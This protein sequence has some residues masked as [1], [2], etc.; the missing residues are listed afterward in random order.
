MKAILSRNVILFISIC[1]MLVLNKEGKAQYVIPNPSET[2]PTGNVTPVLPAN[3]TS[4]QIINYIRTITPTTPVTVES[5]IQTTDY[6]QT[7]VRTEYM[8]GLGRTIQTVDHFTSPATND[9]VS[10]VKYDN[11]G[12]SAWQF[13]PYT[14]TETT[15]SDNGKFKLNAYSEQKDFYKNTMGYTADNYFYTQINYEASPLNRPIYSMPQGSS[16]VGNTRGTSIIENSLPA[17]LNVRHFTIAYNP[18]SLPVTSAVYPT[19]DLM[20]KTTTDEDG[21][22]TE[23][24]RNKTDQVILKAT[25][26]NGVSTKLL[27]YYVYD[28]FGLLRFVIP[29]KATVWLAA[30][31]WTLTSAVA[32]DL[33]FS[34]EYDGRLRQILKRTP[35]SGTQYQ[36]Y[37]NR[38]ELILTQTPTQAA[39]GEWMFNKYDVLGRAIQTGIYNSTASN[40]SLQSLANASNPGSDSFLAYLF[41]NTIYGNSAYVTTFANAKVLTTNYY[42]DYSFTTRTYDNSYMSSIQEGWN[43]VQSNQTRGLLTGTKVVVLDG[44]I[45]PTTLLSVHFYNDRGLLLQTQSQNHKGGWNI[46]TNSY[47]FQGKKLGT[48]THIN[49]PAATDNANIKTIEAFYYDHAGRL[50]ADF[51][52][53]NGQPPIPVIANGFDELGRLDNKNFSNGSDPT[54][55]Y[56]YNVRNWLTGINRQYCLNASTDQTFGMELSYN[57]GYNAKYYN[58]NIAGMKWRNSGKATE[59]RSY[60]YQYDNYNRLKLADY[61]MQ[62]GAQNPSAGWNNGGKN[63]T[64]SN[65]TYD[66][67]GN[68]LTMKQ[69]GVNP[70][71]TTIVLDDLLY[72]YNA[73]SNKLLSVTESANSQS[74]NPTVYDNM[75]DFRDVTGNDY[76]Y[77][78]NGNLLTDANKSI[79]YSYDE[80]VNKT[81]RATKGSQNVDY[82]YDAFG[83]RLQKKVNPGPFTTTDY[84]GSAVYNN[85]SLSFIS[86]PEGRIRY[87]ASASIPYMYDYFI[88]DHLGSIRSVIT[89]TNGTITGTLKVSETPVTKEIVYLATSEPENAVKENQLFDNIETTRSPNL[90]KKVQNDNYVAKIY[91][92]NN[93]TILGPD[94][95]IRVMAGDTIKISAEALYISEKTNAKEIVNNAVNSFVTAFATPVSLA[96]EGISTTE[97]SGITNLAT[98]ILN[99]QNEKSRNGEPKAFLNYILYDDQMNLIT[100]GSGMLQ[101]QEKDGWQTLKTDQ[102]RIS[103]NGFL[104]VFSNNQE[105]A[106][107]SINNTMLTVIPGKLVEE[108][109]YYPY[110]LVFGASS[111]NS[112]IKKTDYLYNG[113]ELQ[114]N[115]FGVGNGLE[116]EDYGARFYDPQIAKW[117]LVDPLAENR[118]S[119]SPYNY[120]K[121][122][123]I[124]KI[125]PTGASDDDYYFNEQGQLLDYVATGKK[126]R[127]FQKDEKGT[128]TH[129][130]DGVDMNFSENK[131]PGFSMV[132]VYV[133]PGIPGHTAIGI[134]GNTTGFYPLVH[135][136]GS[137][138]G[139]YMDYEEYSTRK[140]E[141][142]YPNANIFFLKVTNSEKE[143]IKNTLIGMVGQVQKYSAPNY[144]LFG[145]NCTTQA[146]NALNASNLPFKGYNDFDGAAYNFGKLNFVTPFS[147]NNFLK[148]QYLNHNIGSPVEAWMDRGG[149]FG[150]TSPF[151]NLNKSVLHN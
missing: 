112:S 7:Q 54:I 123:P 92:K 80:I 118:S 96:V 150:P 94:I 22:F 95:T 121:N 101:V 98:S 128:E 81:K 108:Y 111:A 4:G 105:A 130:V 18:G 66:E 39:K 114:H 89:I 32:N 59:L 125:D 124:S 71:G 131:K 113:K 34:Y 83:N 47:D 87:N 137:I 143:I 3:F 139:D 68:L 64:T 140:F 38:D 6:S 104:R 53:L 25:G 11:L 141:R 8:D 120:C 149:I 58:G 48:Y 67:N 73:N 2:Y 127:I 30:N 117:A 133:D 78:A 31:S 20:V 99:M 116:L 146:C 12:H 51:E 132:N 102:I 29:P 126:D 62:T 97:N 26:K 37:N 46:V 142:M 13:L 147:L 115:E 57:Y 84:V 1:S 134:D 9:V 144:Y 36:I 17:G 79:T 21:Y 86:H 107:V 16:W 35:G 14:K 63:F 27:T 24:Y 75:G 145:I 88:K 76:T 122:S 74:K 72:A 77:D 103:N 61:M 100:E 50:L 91:S 42:D 19:G 85:N 136:A 135:N 45:T 70:A 110:G 69:M 55:K 151:V 15:V 93:K 106:P 40:T 28:D 56:E 129:N 119:L 65:I 90:K 10:I 23:E 43:I 109:N 82:L 138:L 44:A 33:C 60:G 148:E 49:N 52:S 5:N 41:N